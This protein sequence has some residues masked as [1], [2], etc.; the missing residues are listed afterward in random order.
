MRK[1]VRHVN[2]KGKRCKDIT[3][4]VP[5]FVG[6]HIDYIEIYVYSYI[7]LVWAANEKWNLFMRFLRYSSVIGNYL[8]TSKRNYFYVYYVLN[9]YFCNFHNNQ[10][11]SVNV[12]N[13][14][15]KIAHHS[16]TL[17]RNATN[18]NVQDNS[19]KWWHTIFSKWSYLSLNY[20][21]FFPSPSAPKKIIWLIQKNKTKK[22]IYECFYP[23]E[24]IC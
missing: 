8:R 19:V 4:H 17:A 13:N 16:R 10:R 6:I 24:D 12:F 18:P 5:L 23:S 3:K 20:T 14:P 21:I 7:C 11:H 1:R 2:T 9:T 22:T 15:T